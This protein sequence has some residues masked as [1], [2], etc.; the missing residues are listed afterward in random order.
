M[1]F[2]RTF[3]PLM[4]FYLIAS[5]MGYS[6]PGCPWLQV[7]PRMYCVSSAGSLLH[8]KL[9]TNTP[10]FHTTIVPR[11]VTKPVVLVGSNRVEL[12]NQSYMHNWDLALKMGWKIVNSA[13][14]CKKLHAQNNVWNLN[15]VAKWMLYNEFVILRMPSTREKLFVFNTSGHRLASILHY[16]CIGSN[17]AIMQSHTHTMQQI[18][19]QWPGTLTPKSFSLV[20]SN[21]SLDSLLVNWRVWQ[22]LCV[23]CS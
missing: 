16:L 22:H 12:E 7:C 23:L 19:T 11:V 21:P 13:C 5:I 2:L 1:S 3:I 9:I 18:Q 4:H 15:G 17:I 6:S 10:Q 8:L 14:T 20:K